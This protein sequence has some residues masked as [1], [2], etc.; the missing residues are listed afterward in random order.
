MT[1]FVEHYPATLHPIDDSG[2]FVPDGVPVEVFQLR[3]GDADRLTEWAGVTGYAG[4][5]GGVLLLDDGQAVGTVRLGEFV[6]RDSAGLRVETSA[7][8]L[9]RQYQPAD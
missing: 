8:D 7:P 6:V 3:P 4:A 2:E 1:A 5:D 9:F